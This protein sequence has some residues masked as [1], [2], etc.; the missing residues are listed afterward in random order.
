MSTERSRHRWPAGVAALLMLVLAG[1]AAMA[2]EPAGLLRDFPRGQLVLETRGPRCL[3]ISIY[4]A[5]SPQQRSQG[6]MFI[7]SMAEFEG[8]YFGYEEPVG[9]AM[10]MKN[11]PLALDMLF[12]RKDRRIASIA[13]NTTPLSTERIESQEAVTGVLELNAGF[14]RRWGVEVGTRVYLDGGY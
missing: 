5:A 4:I 2:A 12:I 3:L 14:A 7:E 10:W 11:T 6:L 8:M 13:R 9:I 1:P